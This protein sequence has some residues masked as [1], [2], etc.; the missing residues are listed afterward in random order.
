VPEAV[1]ETH[2]LAAKH[3]ASLFLIIYHSHFRIP[4]PKDPV[5]AELRL[6]SMSGRVGYYLLILLQEIWASLMAV[7]FI[8]WIVV[9]TELTSSS[10]AL[11]PYWL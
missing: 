2:I 10:T 3:H 6:M 8:G 7:L 11:I 9:D 5:L 1:T 4:H